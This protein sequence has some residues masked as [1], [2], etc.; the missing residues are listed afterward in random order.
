MFEELAQNTSNIEEKSDVYNKLSS[1]FMLND[2]LDKAIHYQE[3]AV[4]FAQNSSDNHT[5]PYNLLEL[6]SL[7]EQ[8]G[9]R[10][11][12]ISIMQKVCNIRGENYDYSH[13]GVLYKENNQIAEAKAALNKALEINPHDEY[14]KEM[15]AEINNKG[16]GGFF[17]K[18]F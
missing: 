3:K 18:W 4:H 16:K 13:L 9:N 14:S 15:L 10:N 2:D 8:K 12:A 1:A 6:S 5:Y 17:S 11:E 7:Y